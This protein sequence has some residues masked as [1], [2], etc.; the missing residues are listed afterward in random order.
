MILLF[1]LHLLGL[2]IKLTLKTGLIIGTA[3]VVLGVISLL[4]HGP[5]FAGFGATHFFSLSLIG[6]WARRWHAGLIAMY[7][8]KA[9]SVSLAFGARFVGIRFRIWLDTMHRANSCN[10]FGA[11]GGQRHHRSRNFT[12]SG[13]FRGAGSAFLL[14]ALGIGEF[15][16]F[17]QNF[18]KYLHAVEV[19]SGALLLFVGGLVFVNKLTWLSGKLTFLNRF[20][21]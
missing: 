1:G 19:F 18:R 3:L 16:R 17:Y 10:G 9:K 11:R 5:L 14:T 21:L 2:L 12:V 13:L 6:F 7:V 15:L 8:Y 20:S 4:R